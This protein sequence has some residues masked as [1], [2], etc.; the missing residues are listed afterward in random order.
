M[1]NNMRPVILFDILVNPSSK[2]TRFTNVAGT[3]TSGSK[4]MC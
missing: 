2:M 4:F 3:T 1:F